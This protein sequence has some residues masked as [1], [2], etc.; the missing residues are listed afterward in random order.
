MAVIRNDR[1]RPQSS[2]GTTHKR[3]FRSRQNWDTLRDN[4]PPY[5]PE[6][7]DEMA[8]LLESVKNVS[9]AD[10]HMSVLVKRMTANFDE[11]AEVQAGTPNA[12]NLMHTT[13][14]TVQASTAAG[15]ALLLLLS[16]TDVM[17]YTRVNSFRLDLV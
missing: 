13:V 11:F 10:P 4:P 9:A 8:E 12:R 3:L 14:C 16:E 17:L 15:V 2:G 5:K 1:T 7:S 6:R